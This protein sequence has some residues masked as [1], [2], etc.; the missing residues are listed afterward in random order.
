MAGVMIVGRE[1]YRHGYHDRHGPSSKVREA[2]AVPL[3]A[4]GFFLISSLAFIA[5][6]RQTGAFFGR[7]KF[8]RYFTHTPYDKHMEE[9]VKKADWAKKGISEKAKPMLP[10]HPKIM[11]YMEEVQAKRRGDA[12]SP[13]EKRRKEEMEKLP[14]IG[15]DM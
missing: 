3:N 13:L 2:G 8:V 5:L 4:A 15:S 7:R 10:M 14:N 6:K 1:L 9:V 12:M 11:E